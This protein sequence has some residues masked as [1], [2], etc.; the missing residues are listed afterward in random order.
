MV[1]IAAM[2]RRHGPAYRAPWGDRRLPRPRRAMQDIERCRTAPRGGP[3]DPG[4]PCQADHDRDHACQPRHGPQ[5]QPDHAQPW[6]E[7]Q[8][9]LRL[10]VPHVMVTWTLPAALR[11]LARRPQPTLDNR[12]LRSSADA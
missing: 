10:P 11:G 6:L 5:C 4:E 8:P 7:H 12:L 3:V 9:R 1:E 2:F